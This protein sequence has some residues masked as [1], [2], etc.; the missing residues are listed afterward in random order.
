MKKTLLLILTICSL[1]LLTA[2][3]QRSTYEQM[4]EELEGGNYTM[5]QANEEA[6]R[7]MEEQEIAEEPEEESEGSDTSNTMKRCAGEMAGTNYLIYL[8]GENAFQKVTASNGGK[9][10]TWLTKFQ[11]CAL[12][13][14]SDAPKQCFDLSQ[15]EYGQHYLSMQQL[16]EEP[17][18]SLMN[19]KCTNVPYEDGV[20]VA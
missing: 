2:C 11:T 6:Q 5:E 7:L 9:V 20:F 16:T 8:S 18:A 19:I 15:A 13:E 17:M 3:N 1:L 14:P 10:Y 4:Q 12:A